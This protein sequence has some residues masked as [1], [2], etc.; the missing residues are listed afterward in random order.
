MQLV[1]GFFPFSET[2]VGCLAVLALIMAYVPAKSLSM[3]PAAWKLDYGQ[4]VPGI[5]SKVSYSAGIEVLVEANSVMAAA[6]R[7]SCSAASM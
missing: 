7:S 5:A 6:E 2:V 3:I 1:L 4:A